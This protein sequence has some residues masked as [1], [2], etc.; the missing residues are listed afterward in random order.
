M[1][2]SVAIFGIA[3]HLMLG[4]DCYYMYYY[5]SS[6]SWMWECYPGICSRANI[7]YH[8]IYRITF[9]VVVH[10]IV[11]MFTILV[12]YVK[13]FWTPVVFSSNFIIVLHAHC[14]LHTTPIRISVLAASSGAEMQKTQ[15]CIFLL[16]R[17]SMEQEIISE[18]MTNQ[19]Q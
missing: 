3:E 16:T 9:K 6:L 13:Q 17:L 18:I 15:Y 5:P 4:L 19:N 8:C 14:T 7:W 11:Q 10:L 12:C 1:E 2:Q